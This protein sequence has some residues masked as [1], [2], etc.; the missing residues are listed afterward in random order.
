METRVSYV[1]LLLSYMKGY[2]FFIIVEMITIA[3]HI[4]KRKVTLCLDFFEYVQFFT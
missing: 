1:K 2:S 3:F 4:F